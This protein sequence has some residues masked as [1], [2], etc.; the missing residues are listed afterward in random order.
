MPGQS[1]SG[2]TQALEI[3]N[4]KSTLEVNE[5]FGPTIQ[6]EGPSVG[7]RCAFL[8]LSGCNL[9]CSWCDTPY[10]WDWKGLNGQVWD[11]NK[12]THAMTTYEVID[13]LTGFDV[14]L[15]IISGGEPMMQQNGLAFLVNRL[16]VGGKEI[17]I[18]TNGTISPKIQPTRFNVSPKLANS[19]NRE[20][21]RR[22]INVLS[23]YVGAS[24]FKFVC[25][26]GSDLDEVEQVIAEAGIPRK[27]VWIMPEGRDAETLMSNA[28]KI[29]DKAIDLGF[30]ITPRLHVMTWGARRAV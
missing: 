17:E 15:I 22:K 21:K 16:M 7:R 28:E 9:T 24:I 5:I 12:E 25:Q 20:G 27:D 8:R 11:K 13:K 30:N 1:M 26:Q 10:T 2:L 3:Q 4:L 29:T 23:Q 18:E 6:G 19:G 14:D